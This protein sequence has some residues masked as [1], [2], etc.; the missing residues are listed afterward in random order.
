MQ[1]VT[2]DVIPLTVHRVA[3]ADTGRDGR[4]STGSSLGAGM[5][6]LLGSESGIEDVEEMGDGRQSAAGLERTL[7]LW[8]GM[9]M[10]IGTMI[11][12]GIFS[13]TSLILQAVGS[14][15]MSMGV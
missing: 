14:V 7:G 8:S 3:E 5:D 15:G 12:S 11:G 10:V 13:T 6:S 2:T 4:L 1:E 9:A